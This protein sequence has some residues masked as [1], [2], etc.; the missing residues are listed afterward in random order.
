MKDNPHPQKQV[1]G[2]STTAQYA[3]IPKTKTYNPPHPIVSPKPVIIL[4]EE[5]NVTWKSSEAKSL[6]IQE[7]LQ[8]AIVAKLSYGRYDITDLRRSIPGKCGIQSEFTI[9]VLDVRHIL[10]R[11][12]SLEDNVQLLSAS[13]V[14]VKEMEKLLPDE[15]H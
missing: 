13:A 11:L 1:I 6:I 10:I 2:E 3:S 12:M 5:P 14:Y 4:Q 9:G 15:S 8:Y 7:N